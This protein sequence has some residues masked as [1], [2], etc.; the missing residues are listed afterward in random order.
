MQWKEK[1]KAQ[2]M[3]KTLYLPLPE[4]QLRNVKWIFLIVILGGPIIPFLAVC[5]IIKFCRFF[6][7]AEIHI[8]FYTHYTMFTFIFLAPILKVIHFIPK[9]SI[10]YNL[11]LLIL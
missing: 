8:F 9:K 5:T 7:T 11:S 3:L 1:A 2:A 6:W 4:K 10:I